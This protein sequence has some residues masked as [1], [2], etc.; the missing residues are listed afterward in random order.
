MRSALKIDDWIKEK[1]TAVDMALKLMKN[2]WI[3]YNP[4]KEYPTELK[5]EVH[6]QELHLLCS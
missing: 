3:S 4:S 6:P 2:D 5:N 1:D